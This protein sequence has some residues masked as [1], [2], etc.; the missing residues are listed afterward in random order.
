MINHRSY[1]DNPSKWLGTCVEGPH[2]PLFTPW[3][4]ILLRAAVVIAVLGLIGKVSL[5]IGG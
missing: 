5:Y 3:G 2:R 1:R 4:K